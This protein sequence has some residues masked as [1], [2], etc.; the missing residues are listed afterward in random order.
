[1]RTQIYQ[2]NFGNKKNIHTFASAFGGLAQL[3]RAP[4]LQAGG[5]RFDSD[6]LH[7][8]RLPLGDNLLCF[9]KENNK[10]SVSDKSTGALA[11]LVERNTGSVEV[12]GSSPLC[13]TSFPVSYFSYLGKIDCSSGSLGSLGI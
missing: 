12:S 10:E 13:S 4:A 7:N 3:A 2:I 5:R 9:S 6:I 8:W 11:H 1:M